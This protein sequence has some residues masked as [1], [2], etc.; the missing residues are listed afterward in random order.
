MLGKRE[1]GFHEVVT[2]L[3]TVE[4]ADTLSLSLA[5]D[6]RI[7]CDLLQLETVEN[8]VVK[9][10]HLLRAE[11]GC[12]RGVLAR[13]DK[14][15]P[16]GGLGGHSADAAAAIRGL[17]ELWGLGLSKQRMLEL[18]ASIGSDAPFCI[19]GGTALC[20]G[21]GDRVSPLPSLP[22][23]WVVLLAPEIEL[24]TGKTGKLYGSMKP[25][26]FTTG[27]LAREMVAGL[28]Q[29]RR[30][31][32]GLFNAFDV[33]AFDFFPGLGEYRSRFLQA[34][35]EDVHLAGAGPVLFS[36]ESEESRGETIA[37]AL[38]DQGLEAF[39]VR[40]TRGCSY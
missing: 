31:G 26:H 15:I 11:T 38:K 33:V 40:T 37:A 8:S 20:E 2:V 18:A 35:A 39:L 12:Q 21:R 24:P 10:A 14:H 5:N 1:D 16:C 3:Q 9:A 6:I 13:L 7:E 30:R 17:D 25:A 32:G 23:S 22:Q 4:L 19:Y 36:L 28:R 27:G 34:G 29:G